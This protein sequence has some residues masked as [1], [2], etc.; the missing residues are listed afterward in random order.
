MLS[1]SPDEAVARN[2]RTHCVTT[3]EDIDD[4][5]SLAGCEVHQDSVT[6]HVLH[7]LRQ[8]VDMAT[9]QDTDVVV[10]VSGKWPL[11]TW[12][13]LSVFM[14]EGKMSSSLP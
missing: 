12:I 11:E 10:L 7:V 3:Y 13:M 9:N 14:C 4:V 8:A 1:L 2:G 5:H 6:A